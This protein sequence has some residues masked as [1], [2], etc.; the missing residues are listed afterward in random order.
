ML[1]SLESRYGNIIQEGARSFIAQYESILIDTL[2]DLYLCSDLLLIVFKAKDQDKKPI[3]VYL[4]RWSHVERPGDGHYFVN[5]IY[6][7]GKRH[8]VH[9]S[10]I[11][12]YTCIEFYEKIERVITDIKINEAN[13]E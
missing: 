13:R 11:D 9:L 6:I 4:D 8:C 2:V 5:R 3:R 10:F 12:R 7:F 1:I